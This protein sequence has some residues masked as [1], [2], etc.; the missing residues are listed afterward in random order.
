MGLAFV[1]SAQQQ[2]GNLNGR[3]VIVNG[4]LVRVP[5]VDPALIRPPPVG[6]LLRFKDGSELHGEFQT[7]DPG[8]SVSWRHPDSKTNITFSVT[9]LERLFFTKRAVPVFKADCHLQLTN[10]DEVYGGLVSMDAKEVTV[11]T[12][13]GG[14]ARAPRSAVSGIDKLSASFDCVYDGP[15]GPGDFLI[16]GL[17]GWLYRDGAMISHQIGASLTR[18]FVATNA[19]F[20]NFDVDWSDYLLLRM[21]IYTDTTANSPRADCY[22]L[23]LGANLGD[24]RT[25]TAELNVMRGTDSIGSSLGGG[26]FPKLDGGNTAHCSVQLDRVNGTCALYVNQHLVN[27][28]HG[29]RNI[30]GPWARVIFADRNPR[31]GTAIRRLQ[32]FSQ[33][34]PIMKAGTSG[35]T[36][37]DVVYFVN[38]DKAAGKI[39]EIKASMVVLAVAGRQLEV[40][41]SRVSRL[42]FAASGTPAFGGRT[43][44]APGMARA[45]M[46]GGNYLTVALESWS[47][48]S[49]TVNSPV[50]GRFTLTPQAVRELIFSRGNSSS[51][52]SA[53]DEF[54]GLD[55]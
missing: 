50:L 8:H 12:V 33:S 44:I 3:V 49:I 53:N 26:E 14:L 31:S 35:A 21:M 43:E 47:S 1:V 30:K 2:G 5:E 54:G 52:R 41:M 27:E 20:I 11:K 40:P 36:N 18:D 24:Q 10:G 42:D 38:R 46:G 32:I 28:W 39:V 51:A 4:T 17:G 55:D 13:F 22:T 29:P 19:C 34:E 7:M 45:D 6:D 48:D 9:N 23:S 37:G 25:N 15:L 16:N